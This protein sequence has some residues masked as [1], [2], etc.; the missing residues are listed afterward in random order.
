MIDRSL[1]QFAEKLN[2]DIK[3]QRTFI[4][5]YRSNTPVEQFSVRQLQNMESHLRAL[6]M[7]RIELKT[8]NKVK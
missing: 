4:K 2:S 8:I 7:I 6:E 1:K 5:Q 3:H